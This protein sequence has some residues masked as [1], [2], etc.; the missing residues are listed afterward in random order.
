ML[1]KIYN[2]FKEHKTVM[3]ASLLTLSITF[4]AL[5]FS[6]QYSENIMD[7]LPMKTAEREALDVYQNIS[8]SDK[9]ILLFENND[10]EIAVEAM[11]LFTSIVE[12]KDKEG[13]YSSLFDNPDVSDITQLMNFVYE[14]IPYFLQDEVYERIDSLLNQP[15]YYRSRLLQNKQS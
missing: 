10:A 9:I 12:E 6:L 3:W 14:N 4:F 11:D 1:I 13:L 15:D 5:L 2:Y 7:F 8:G